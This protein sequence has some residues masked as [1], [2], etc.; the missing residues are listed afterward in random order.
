VVIV[1]MIVE[2]T[3]E[4]KVLKREKNNCYK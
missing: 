2:T 4:A 1:S 3:V